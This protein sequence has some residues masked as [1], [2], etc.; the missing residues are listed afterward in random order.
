MIPSNKIIENKITNGGEFMLSQGM[1][2][3]EQ[4]KGFYNKLFNGKSYTGKTFTEDSKELI[5]MDEFVSTDF[6]S[7]ETVNNQSDT[8]HYV[9]DISDKENIA[10]KQVSST[11][12]ESLLAKD[13]RDK[14]HL[15]LIKI[16]SDKIIEYID[17]IE[18]EHPG[19]KAYYYS[20]QDQEINLPRK[21]F[22]VSFDFSK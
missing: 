11:T 13:D 14:D 22:S 9:Q 2:L 15:R 7:F 1:G 4:Y 20:D 3:F 5:P 12:Y 10:F 18:R 17:D 19:F 21:S 16:P 8:L 6:N